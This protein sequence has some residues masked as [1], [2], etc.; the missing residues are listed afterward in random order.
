[1]EASDADLQNEMARRVRRHTLVVVLGVVGSFAA[2][3]LA[4][5]GGNAVFHGAVPRYYFIVYLAIF[6]IPVPVGV[7]SSRINMRCPACNT[8]VVG[9]PRSTCKACNKPIFGR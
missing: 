1:M 3:G 6:L 2:F 5:L 7:A 4:W 9:L 8:S